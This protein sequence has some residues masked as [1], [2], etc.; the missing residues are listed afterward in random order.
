MGKVKSTILLGLAT[1]SVVIV[2]MSYLNEASLGQFQIPMDEETQQPAGNATTGLPGIQGEPG[3][4]GPP[5]PQGEQGPPGP[6]GP[7]GLNGTQGLPGPKG[8]PG[9]QG[10]PGPPG[11]KGMNGTQGPQGEQGPSGPVG[12]PGPQG[13]S[14][15]MGLP[16]PPG[17]NGTQGPPG[18]LGPQGPKGEQGDVGPE[19]PPGPQGEQGPPGPAGDKGD[20]GIPGPIGPVGPQG[21]PGE[22]GMDANLSSLELFTNVSLG[23]VVE[24][25]GPRQF[26]TV[27]STASCDED[28][29]LV[30]GGY[31]ITEGL[32][33][34]LENGPL[35]NTWIVKA[36]NPFP[37]F[38]EISSG[39]LQAYA[40]CLEINAVV[41]HVPPPE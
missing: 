9:E 2:V 12:P 31:N 36:A 16:G 10:P 40:I 41:G 15:P 1:L 21:P 25:P 35:G 6:A 8:E 17:M 33:I 18:P 3:P 38:D 22:P 19:G 39:S 7:P 28:R 11:T 13:E 24:I 30:G 29:V 23:N 4:M 27:E 14:G 26:E 34:V 5:G 32:G 20:T 37:I